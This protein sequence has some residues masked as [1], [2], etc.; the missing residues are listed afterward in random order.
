MGRS[1]TGD[2][3]WAARAG[4]RERTVFAMVE[5]LCGST[6]RYRLARQGKGATEKYLLGRSV[7]GRGE[8]ACFGRFCSVELES[9]F[10]FVGMA[11]AVSVS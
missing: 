4:K 1:R 11:G 7:G 3:K 5:V 8:K 10:I 2:R 9:A 6:D